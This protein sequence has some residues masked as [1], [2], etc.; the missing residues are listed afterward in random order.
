MPTDRN[1]HYL[2]KII[3][4]PRVLAYGFAALITLSQFV[5]ISVGDSFGYSS[6]NPVTSSTVLHSTVW[7]AIPLLLYPH[8]AYW[9]TGCWLNSTE[10]ARNSMLVDSLL[11]GSMIVVNGFHLLTSLSFILILSLSTLL[12]ARPKTMLLSLMILGITLGAGWLLFLPDI[13]HPDSL[14]TD[15]LCCIAILTYSCMVAYMGFKVTVD[16]G[17]SRHRAEVDKQALVSNTEYLRQYLSPQIYAAI[18]A[19]QRQSEKTYRKRLTVF[20]SD[21]EGFTELMDNLEEESVTRTLNE[22]LNA[23]AEI[24]V[25]HG[26]TLDKFMGD[27]IM[28]FFGD[29]ETQGP[30]QDAL[31]CVRMALEMKRKLS[32]LRDKWQQK[33]IFSELHIRI[34]INTGYCAVGNFGSESHMDYTAV[35][36]AVNMASRLESK[37]PRDSIL[38]SDTTRQLIADELDCIQREL[39]ALKGIGRLVDNYL[40]SGECNESKQ[41]VMER[42]IKGLRVSLNPTLVDIGEARQLLAETETAVLATENRR[43]ESKAVV[44][45][46]R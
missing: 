22:Y 45:L 40:V 33:G 32:C 23:M 9:I 44:R 11:V 21:I 16:L 5:G 7:L 19:R 1:F 8:L 6:G 31:S 42:E 25:E 30:R 15:A 28:V 35:G 41:Q 12:I 17:S 27:G 13:S 4:Q 2:I 43:R 14:L 36:G 37:A 18:V 38:V 20:F 29:P 10:G 46:L 3:Y 24:V 34:G 39:L 26:G